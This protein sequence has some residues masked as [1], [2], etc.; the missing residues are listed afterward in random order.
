MSIGF[1]SILAGGAM[2]FPALLTLFS[3]IGML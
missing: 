1:V 3:W 2:L